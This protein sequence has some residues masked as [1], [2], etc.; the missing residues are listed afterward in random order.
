MNKKGFI[1]NIVFVIIG[2]ALFSIVA[3]VGYNTF[4][5]VNDDIQASEMRNQSK[6]SINDLHN[7]YPSTL[8][9]AFLTIFILL[10]ILAMVAGWM[11]DSNPLFIIVV[12]IGM[13]LLLVGAGFMSNVW[14]D[15]SNDSEFI[16][17]SSSF[18]IMNF[19][20]ENFLLNA[21][22]VAMSVMG[23]MFMKSRVN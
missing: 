17:F 10:W 15:F 12:G 2:L 21:V 23:L 19:V 11:A 4:T 16:T 22:V 3:L 20:L 8:D 1:Q 13:I 7:R 6:A 14:D 18:P 5:E 9:G